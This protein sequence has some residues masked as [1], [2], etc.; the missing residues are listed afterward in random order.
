MSPAARLY[1][2]HNATSPLRSTARA[3]MLAALE[4]VGNP[5]SVHADGRAARK[6]LEGARESVAARFFAQPAAVTFTSGATES[7]HLALESA[8]ALGFG[9]CLIGAGEHDAAYAMARWLY[10]DAI[11]VPLTGD[12]VMDTDGLATRLASVPKGCKPLIIAQAANNETGVLM[13]MGRIADLARAVGGAVL[14]DAVQFVGREPLDALAGAT[15]WMAASS[16]KLGGPMGVGVL[17][18]GPAVGVVN[19]RPGGGQEV[20]ARAGTQ[21]VP[22]IAGFAAALDACVAEVADVTRLRAE[23]DAFE[24]RLMA[25]GLGCVV[26]GAQAP[27]LA[28]TACVAL[29]GWMAEKQVIALDL[30]GVSV[31]AGAACSSGK[32]KVSRVLL[33]CGVGA[34]L[35]QS[36][37]RISFGWSTAPGDGERLADVYIKLARAR[38]AAAKES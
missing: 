1:A 24:A 10:P 38:R 28:N 33:A 11:D 27:R 22:A 13:P 21:N 2:D 18:S 26:I 32:V 7:L 12:G 34:E 36:A 3:A 20:G 14:C 31:S 19:Q 9:P 4:Q 30:A 5:S 35:A 37:I 16:H 23:R 15:D 6:L 29:A 17:I 8:K 25:A